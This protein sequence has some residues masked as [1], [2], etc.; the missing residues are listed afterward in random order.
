M[1]SVGAGRGGG[2]CMKL[3]QPQVNLASS[4]HPKVVW[5]ILDLCS[6]TVF[7]WCVCLSRSI[8]NCLHRWAWIWGLLQDAMVLMALVAAL[9]CRALL[10]GTGSTLVI[11]RCLKVG[12]E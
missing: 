9:C 10:G 2:V 3:P 11:E 4:M 12:R 1:G 5:G 8:V 7:Q 6:V